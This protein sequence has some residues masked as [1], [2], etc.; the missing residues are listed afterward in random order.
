MRLQICIPTWNRAEALSRMLAKLAP[1]AKQFGFGVLVSDNGSTDNTGEVV[2][3]YLG[4]GWFRYQRHDTNLGFDRNVASLLSASDADY[5][6]LQGDDDEVV[7]DALPALFSVLE[8]QPAL[9]WTNI[10]TTGMPS[11]SEQRALSALDQISVAEFCSRFGFLGGFGGLAHFVIRRERLYARKLADYVGSNYLHA[12]A[13]A[14]AFNGEQMHLVHTPLTQVTPR[15]EEETARY[16]A[17]WEMQRGGEWDKAVLHQAKLLDE[18]LQA[19]NSTDPGVFRMYDGAHYPFQLLLL[20]SVG[21]LRFAGG[22]ISDAQMCLTE[23]L[24]QRVPNP[25]FGQLAATTRSLSMPIPDEAEQ[26]AWWQRY[27]LA[28]HS[29]WMSSDEERSAA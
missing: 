2:V 22:E 11:V 18:W 14:N 6:W 8:E 29:D 15:T 5:V 21:C 28:G 27:R 26:T 4:S 16:I 23:R 1:A 10:C 13:L 12:F 20:K 9:V 25:L 17:R 24:C 19:S 7:C 3:P